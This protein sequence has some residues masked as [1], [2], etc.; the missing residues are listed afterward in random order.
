[1]D[2][3][4]QKV[5]ILLVEDSP[6]DRYMLI[7]HFNQ[8]PE[9][10]CE[11]T[12]VETGKDGIA[13][14]SNGGDWDLVVIDYSLPDMTGLE[15]L[16]QLKTNP[17]FDITPVVMATGQG[18]ESVA[19]EAMKQG[20]FDYLIKGSITLSGLTRV[21]KNALAKRALDLRIIEEASMRAAAEEELRQSQLLTAE[22]KAVQR[23][24][25]TLAHEINNPLTGIIG[26]LQMATGLNL[27]CDDG[28]KM[29]AES[30]EAAKRIRD[31][32]AKL[33]RLEEVGYRPYLG[34][35]KIIDLRED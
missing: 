12:E 29:L 9:R 18:S 31:V 28:Q 2:M 6:D 23:T 21:L 16:A 10:E 1:M 19:V 27:D 34:D 33:S 25:A 35:R 5:Q 17:A 32:V 4:V 15:L 22:L 14:F 24:V 7:R 8:F 11:I 13:T 3:A 26:N 20:A 30:L